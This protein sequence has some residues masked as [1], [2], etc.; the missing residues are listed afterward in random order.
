MASG[1]IM[2]ER[3]P[4]FSATRWPLELEKGVYP[5]PV[6]TSSASPVRNTLPGLEL[7]ME[8]CRPA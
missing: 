1:K 2:L 4:S 6:P 5:G 8:S 7:L 3:S